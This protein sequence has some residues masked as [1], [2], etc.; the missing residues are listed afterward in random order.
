MAPAEPLA[1]QEAGSQ[2]TTMGMRFRFQLG[3]YFERWVASLVPAPP[4]P[5][6]Q[7]INDARAKYPITNDVLTIE[8]TPSAQFFG[9]VGAG[10]ATD[11]VKLLADVQALLAGAA[12][13]LPASIVAIATAALTRF[14]GYCTSIFELPPANSV[15]WDSKWL[16]YSFRVTSQVPG[17]AAATPPQPA[18]PTITLGCTDFPGGYLDW[19]AFTLDAAS[20]DLGQDPPQYLSFLPTHISFKGAP[21]NSHWH[22]EDAQSDFGQLDVEK[23]NLPGVI[24]SEFASIYGNDWFVVPVPMQIG[25]VASIDTVVIADTF[26]T[27]TLIRPTAAAT[28]PGAA[29]TMFTVSGGSS[30]GDMV[31]LAPM[32]GRVDDGPELEIV[33]FLRDDVAALGWGV[34]RR[35]P[36]PMDVGIDAFESF[37]VRVS[38][39]PAPP[40]TLDPN[41]QVAYVL[42]TTVPDNWIPLVPTLDPANPPM[43]LQRGVMTREMVNASGANVVLSIEPRGIILS[44][45]PLI[46]AD[47]AVSNA[48]LN[49]ARYCRRA[50]LTDGSVALWIARQTRPGC[51]PGSSGLLFDQLKT[52]VPE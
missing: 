35:V 1:E 48:G 34:E 10:R 32:L 7:I 12:N 16:R 22:F 6:T 17:N 28:P 15:S 5:T 42:G 31:L 20:A 33:D 44:P 24:V 38:G 11:G 19:F 40:P 4:N 45:S 2:G 47:Q 25:S 49:V 46:I 3:S 21:A 18:L 8:D 13:A 43:Y 52:P 30:G 29:W 27:R 9:L 23:S 41:T 37:L 26:G 14:V 51:G 39:Q 50:R 36:G